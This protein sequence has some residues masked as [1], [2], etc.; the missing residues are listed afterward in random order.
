HGSGPKGLTSA[1]I[2]R[3]AP[4]LCGPG[5]GEKGH[6]LSGR[7]TRW[8]P[9]RPVWFPGLLRLLDCPWI[10]PEDFPVMAVGVVEAPAVHEAVILRVAGVLPARCDGLPDHLVYAGRC[11]G[12]PK[13]G[14]SVSVSRNEFQHAMPS[15]DSSTTMSAH[16]W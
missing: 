16:G 7:A 9:G 10:H 8:T 1:A 15:P 6:P 4:N 11:R 12:S 3:S 13:R 2:Q 5:P 14:N